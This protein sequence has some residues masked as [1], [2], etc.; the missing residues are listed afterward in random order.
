M[1]DM[2]RQAADAANS[3]EID[4]STASKGGEK[5]LIPAGTYVGRLIEYIEFGKQP[6]EYKGET[7]SPAMEIQLGFAIYGEGV[8]KEDGSPRVIST[9]R[10]KLSN[11]EKSKTF[12]IFSR[13]NWKKDKKTFAQMLGESFLVPIVH[14]TNG[15]GTYA[16]IDTDNIAPAIDPISR[17]EYPCPVPPEDIYRVFLW[18]HPTKEMWD[19]IYIESNNFLQEICLGA[20][21]FPNS[22]LDQM[23]NGTMPSLEATSKPIDNED[24][25]F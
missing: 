5:F 7:K 9:Y 24:V 4:M 15:K 14:L 13:M 1:F 21:N 10:M 25:P 12:K 8:T 17:R 22:K 2:I 6:Q 16:R 19:S 23:L 3:T 20:T 11:N 18:N